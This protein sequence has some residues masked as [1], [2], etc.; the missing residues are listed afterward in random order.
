MIKQN[1]I[2]LHYSLQPSPSAKLDRGTPVDELEGSGITSLLWIGG[3]LF[4]S[5]EVERSR[6]LRN[7]FHQSPSIVIGLSDQ[8]ATLPFG[9]IRPLGITYL[10]KK[11]P[12]WLLCGHLIANTWAKPLSCSAHERFTPDWWASLR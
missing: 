11:C 5:P 3:R 6:R 1:Y 4:S 10:P 9:R 2:M 8:E 7:R 12:I